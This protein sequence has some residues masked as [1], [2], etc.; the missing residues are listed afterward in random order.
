MR[1]T[2]QWWRWSPSWLVNG[3]GSS[4]CELLRLFLLGE[5][6]EQPTIEAH[7]KD[8]AT[9]LR[10]HVTRHLTLLPQD[11]AQGRSAF[12]ACSLAK[13]GW[14]VVRSRCL[15][16]YGVVARVPASG[17]RGDSFVPDNLCRE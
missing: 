2:D 11:Q 12:Q 10:K 15:V 17:R 5:K 6:S 3:A 4:G 1:D 7:F 16:I 8:A 9:V 13:R 14:R